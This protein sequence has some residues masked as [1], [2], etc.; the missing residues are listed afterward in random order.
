MEYGAIFLSSVVTLCTICCNIKELYTI[1]TE[2]TSYLCALHDYQNQQNF[3]FPTEQHQ[4]LAMLYETHI[5][6][7]TLLS[8]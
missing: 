3:L 4:T 5:M 2:Y 1:F 8:N 6:L 7:N